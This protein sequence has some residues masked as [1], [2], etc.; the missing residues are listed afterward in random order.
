MATITGD[1]AANILDGTT[2]DDFIYGLDGND[3]L[4]AYDGNDTIY[5]D[6]SSNQISQLTQNSD[7]SYKTPS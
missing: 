6:S 3:T 1:S 4:R 2:D 5:G 7:G